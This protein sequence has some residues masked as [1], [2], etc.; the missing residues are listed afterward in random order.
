MISAET[1]LRIQTLR[2]KAMSDTATTEELREALN[3]LRG[4]RTRA[5]ATSTK[6]KTTKAAAAKPIDSDDLLNE[7]GGL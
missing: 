7:L 5:S 2:A 1:S 3:L 4:D 6:A